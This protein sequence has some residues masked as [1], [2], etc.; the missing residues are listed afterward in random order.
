MKALIG[1]PHRKC[2]LEPDFSSRAA[3]SIQPRRIQ[4]ILSLRGVDPAAA[5][6]AA[7]AGVVVAGV[8][9]AKSLL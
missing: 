6:A 4:V 5:L 9:V 1:Q 3:D 8:V 7:V 2:G